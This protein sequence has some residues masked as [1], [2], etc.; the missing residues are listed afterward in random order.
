M[1][2]L[3]LHSKQESSPCPLLEDTRPPTKGKTTPPGSRLCVCD[4]SCLPRFQ[5]GVR[6]RPGEARVSKQPKISL[7]LPSYP[8]A[9]LPSCPLTSQEQ[10]P[11]SGKARSRHKKSQEEP[12]VQ[13]EPLSEDGE[14]PVGEQEGGGLVTTPVPPE[15]GTRTVELSPGAPTVNI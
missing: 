14:R 6:R 7:H 10:D 12:G 9:L 15:P 3:I 4:I 8:P 5:P 13:Q 1:F 11:E 2:T